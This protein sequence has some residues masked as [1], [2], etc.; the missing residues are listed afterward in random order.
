[1]RI[2]RVRTDAGTFLTRLEGD[3]AVPIA[4]EAPEPGRD[5]L[6]D[7][8]HANVDVATAAAIG[9]AIALDAA[10]LLS[11]VREPQKLLA[12]GL[13]YADHAR[14]AGVDPPDHPVLFVK[15]PN[16][17]IGPGEP[18]VVDAE[19]STQVDYEAELAVVIG[20][21]ADRVDRS[22][23][24]DH[25]LGY[26][27]C[28]DVSARDAQFAD[29]QW[30][31]GK[32]FDTFCPL[33]PWIVTTDEIADP[34]SLPIR[35][36]VNDATLQDSSTAEMIF[37]VAELVS[38]LSHGLTLEPGDVIATGTPFGVGFVRQPPVFL[39]PGDTV[40]VEVEGIGT[41]R[42]PVAGR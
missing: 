20:R 22:E 7:L 34:Q 6:R 13:N 26:T 11:P 19:L 24:L 9:A 1:V 30:V 23:A 18:I 15:T 29:G 40:E 8:L 36:R 17:I 31:R 33:G 4:A 37:G 25:V 38:Y 28:N 41:L 5:P 39:R 21:R 42:N 14:E 35:C 12:I 16:S 32:S 10:T 2:A 3:K 27:L